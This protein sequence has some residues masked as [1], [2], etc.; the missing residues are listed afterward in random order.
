M[1]IYEYQCNHCRHI[2]EILKPVKL[3]PKTKIKIICEKCGKKS[4]NRII[5]NIGGIIFKGSGFY[6]TDYEMK[7]KD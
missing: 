7:K 1:P 5:S 2:V 3:Q 4:F 6:T